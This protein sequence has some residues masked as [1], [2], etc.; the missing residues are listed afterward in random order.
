MDQGEIFIRDGWVLVEYMLAAN[1][2]WVK[3]S[4][5]EIKLARKASPCAKR[6][7]HDKGYGAIDVV[8]SL[9]GHVVRNYFEPSN[10]SLEGLVQSF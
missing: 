9:A 10:S 8:A 2:L 4:A 6:L 7:Y 3:K 5:G 1:R